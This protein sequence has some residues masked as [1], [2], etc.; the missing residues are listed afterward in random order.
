MCILTYL[1]VRVSMS[2]CVH[3]YSDTFI[4]TY[5]NMKKH[6]ICTH[7]YIHICVHTHTHTFI[8]ICIYLSLYTY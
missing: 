7:M 1:C 8:D 3:L 4:Y 2:V 6:L 5:I